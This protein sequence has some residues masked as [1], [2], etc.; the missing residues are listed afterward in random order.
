MKRLPASLAAG[1]LIL[2]SP[3][4]SHAGLVWFPPLNST[5]P[6]L[7]I[8]DYS[9]FYNGYSSVLRVKF[10][11]GPDQPVW[12]TNCAISRNGAVV[13]HWDPVNSLGFQQML[14]TNAV[15]AMAQG[16]KIRILYRD[17]LCDTA[18]NAGVSFGNRLEGFMII[19]PDQY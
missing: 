8:E 13:G 9:H 10:K 18:N 6:F 2:F 12:N 4:I 15:S 5:G 1:I 3:L 7:E 17:D 14:T 16:Q 11:T 19:S